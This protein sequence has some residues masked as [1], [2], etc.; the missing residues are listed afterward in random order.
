MKSFNKFKLSQLVDVKDFMN[1]V[2]REI[3]F[4]YI[5]YFQMNGI[6]ECL[7]LEMFQSKE[8]QRIFFC[9]LFVIEK[10]FNVNILG[11]QTTLFYYKMFLFKRLFLSVF[12]K[13][14]RRFIV[15]ED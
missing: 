3:L 6:E 13:I 10:K 14:Y 4:L 7:S 1:Y 12:N 15:L 9:I 5:F 8:Y 2:E 11:I